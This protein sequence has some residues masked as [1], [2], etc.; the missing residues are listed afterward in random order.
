MAIKTQSVSEVV[1]TRKDPTL[2]YEVGNH[3]HNS[4]RKHAERFERTGAISIFEAY[5]IY[6]A[7]V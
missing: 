2:L 7:D 5:K 4:N 1:L 6:K 3:C